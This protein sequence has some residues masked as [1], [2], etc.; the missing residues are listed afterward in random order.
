MLVYALLPLGLG[1]TLGT[2][3][4]AEDATA[5]AF[6]KDAFD[7]LVGTDAYDDVVHGGE[8]E[9]RDPVDLAVGN[10]VRNDVYSDDLHIVGDA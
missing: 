10:A 7:A 6:Y 1:G 4:V 3:A 2:A 5:I 9:R 8:R